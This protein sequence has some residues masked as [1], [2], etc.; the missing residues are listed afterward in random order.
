MPS[1]ED[2]MLRAIGLRSIDDLF[3]DI[4]AA[5][6]IPKL[7]LP[8]GL[9]ELTVVR[10]VTSLLSANR[11]MADMPTFL[12]G[13]LYDHFVPASVRAIT[14]RSEFYTAY[15]PYQAELSQG[16]LQT[17]WEYQSLIC[18]LTGMD[19]ANTSMYDASTALGEAARMAHRIHGGNV[20]LIPRALR[21]NRR[22]VLANYL[23]G[24]GI[25]IQEVDYDR[26]TGMLDL[27]KLKGSLSADVCG[28]Y[29]E[30]PNFFGRLEEQLAEIR[31]MTDAVLIVGVNPIAQAVVRPP[32]DFGADIVIGEGQSLGTSVNCGGPLLGIFACRQE[33][34]RKMPGRVIGLTRDAKGHR[35]FCMT[36][37]TREQ[38]IRREKAMSNIC[39]NES[40]LAVAAATFIA[41]MGSNGLRKLAAENIRRAKE[42]AAAIDKIP[43]FTAPV[44]HGAHFN[45]FI[46]RSKRDYAQVHRGLLERGV[47]GGMPLARQLPE[48]KDAALFATTERQKD[49][50]VSR[51]LK[52]LEAVAA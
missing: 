32:G 5:V 19:A 33:H 30:N 49:A 48:L 4:P 6:R 40:L 7:D 25:G 45:E 24:T 44:F 46:V 8:D 51:L 13:G 20:F 12:G 52:A 15:T 35:A 18:E 2:E 1:D 10:H 42:L 39:T 3:A 11:T 47:H 34:I 27:A 28:V 21:H 9:P 17:L 50:D 43:G 41:V 37:Q 29:V 36:L 26:K 14:S 22:A 38:H 31:Q 16:L 23:V